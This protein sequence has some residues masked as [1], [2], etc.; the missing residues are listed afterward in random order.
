MK[1]D[2]SSDDVKRLEAKIDRLQKS[3]NKLEKRLSSHIEF[4]DRV[5]EPLR[6]PISKIK[7]FFG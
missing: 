3:I 6:N 2:Y 4:I 1:S 7:N 5:Y